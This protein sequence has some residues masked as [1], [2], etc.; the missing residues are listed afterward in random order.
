V[1]RDSLDRWIALLDEIRQATPEF[2]ISLD[3][4]DSTAL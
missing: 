1:P 4:F 3:R 2:A